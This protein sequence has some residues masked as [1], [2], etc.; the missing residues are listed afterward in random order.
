[1]IDSLDPDSVML[2]GDVH[3]DTNN[4]LMMVQL[5]QQGDLKVILQ[6]GDFG[7]M[8]QGV[9]RFIHMLNRALKRADIH[10]FWIDGNH[11]NHDRLDMWPLNAHGYHDIHTNI[12]H[13]PRGF[14]WTWGGCKFLACGGAFS[15]DKANRTE[16]LSWWSQEA[17][18]QAD[19]YRCG[20]EPADVLV[21]HDVPEGVLDPYGPWTSGSN[22]DLWPESAANRERLRAVVDAVRPRLVVH[23]HTHCRKSTTLYL[24]DSSRVQ[25]EGFACNGTG[26]D[27]WTVLSME[28]LRNALTR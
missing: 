17:I 24:E 9:D 4:A 27:Q 28:T 7:F 3:G 12:H 8:G 1:M 16:Y 11:E 20:T 5:A 6:L 19:I 23:G 21:S 10:L 15:I 13:L 25:V 22:K 14:R 18:T 26:T 2:L